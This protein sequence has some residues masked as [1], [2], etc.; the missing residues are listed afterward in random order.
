[1]RIAGRI[2]TA[3]AQ[4]AL[5]ANAN[6]MARQC[7]MKAIYRNELVTIVR[8]EAYRAYIVWRGM[9]KRVN[10]RDLE[11]LHVPVQC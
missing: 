7:A 2:R 3:P 1:M 11:V 5:Y 9:V 6:A 8:I 10:K 4:P